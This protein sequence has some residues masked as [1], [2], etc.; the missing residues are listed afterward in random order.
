MPKSS[1]VKK[2]LAQIGRKGGLAKSPAKTASSRAN[3][4]KHLATA[5][6]KLK[7]KP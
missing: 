1:A 5:T 3:G 6:A 2:Y 4:K 7:P